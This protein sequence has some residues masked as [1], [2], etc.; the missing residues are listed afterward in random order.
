MFIK[1]KATFIIIAAHD[2]AL[3]M[4]ILLLSKASNTLQIRQVN[5]L[6]TLV[7]AFMT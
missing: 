2:H 7:S 5:V 6:R 3:N 1:K 4:I